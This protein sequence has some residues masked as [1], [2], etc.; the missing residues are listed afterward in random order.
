MDGDIAAMALPP[1]TA[2]PV[3]RRRE[4]SLSTPNILPRVMPIIRVNDIDIIVIHTEVRPTLMT[5]SRCIPNPRRMTAIWR[6]FFDTFPVLSAAGFPA[7]RAAADPRSNPHAGFDVRIE[8]SAAA[9]SHI[10]R[11]DVMI[12]K[13]FS[14]TD[15]PK[16]NG[17]SIIRV[18]YNPTS[19]MFGLFSPFR[20]SC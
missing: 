13:R 4:R 9:A 5:V 2:V 15:P 17:R 8:S 14:K 20:I 11:S 10:L 12:F 6:S 18:N 16:I 1:H 7:E 3:L 19:G